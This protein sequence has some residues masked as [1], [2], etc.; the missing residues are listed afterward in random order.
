M[1]KFYTP[2]SSNWKLLSRKVLPGRH[3]SHSV[4][5][6]YYC[7]NP[8][9]PFQKHLQYLTPRNFHTSNAR[10]TWFLEAI[11]HPSICRRTILGWLK[12][13]LASSETCGNDRRR[14]SKI[15]REIS[16]LAQS[17]Q[18]KGCEIT[19]GSGKNRSTT[20]MALQPLP[21]FDHP[22]VGWALAQTAAGNVV[23]LDFQSSNIS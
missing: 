17:K 12:E 8:P 9:E 20:L 13:V 5:S 6:G 3:R 16:F 22:P 14:T 1:G 18:G 4:E 11:W 7:G 23:A 15:Y 2:S 21:S 10:S 19:F